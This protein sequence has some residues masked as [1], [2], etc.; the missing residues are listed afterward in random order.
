MELIKHKLNTMGKE[1]LAQHIKRGKKQN[2]FKNA[3]KPGR[4]LVY[5]LKKEK[6]RKWISKLQ[7]E[8]GTLHCQMKKKKKIYDFYKKLYDYEKYQREK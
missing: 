6:E 3:N 8:G 2:F 5:R 4:R 1:E 7:D